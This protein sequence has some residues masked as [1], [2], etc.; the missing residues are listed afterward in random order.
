MTRPSN[1]RL[2]HLE[3]S[4]SGQPRRAPAGAR[5][6]DIPVTTLSQAYLGNNASSAMV[7]RLSSKSPAPVDLLTLQRLP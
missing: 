2:F 6:R 3:H 1:Y 7:D 5:C 4:L